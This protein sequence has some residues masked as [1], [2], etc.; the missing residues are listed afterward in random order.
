MYFT[1]ITSFLFGLC[2]LNWLV[3]IGWVGWR[4]LV[5]YRHWPW[6]IVVVVQGVLAAQIYWLFRLMDLN[7][8]F[9]PSLLPWLE[10]P[11][12]ILFWLALLPWIVLSNLLPLTQLAVS[13]RLPFPD[14]LDAAVDY[15][16]I[17]AAIN[18]FLVYRAHRLKQASLSKPEAG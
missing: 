11:G 12:S 7:V 17:Y 18:G 16:L 4:W 13:L 15:G 1:P 5:Q 8:Y 3:L 10:I 14:M 6:P 9:P 2:A